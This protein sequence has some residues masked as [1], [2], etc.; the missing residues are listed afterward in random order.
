[1][2]KRDMFINVCI[3]LMGAMLVVVCPIILIWA[4]NTLFGTQT[5]FNANTWCAAL[6]F[7][8]ML[9]GGKGMKTKIDTN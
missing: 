3:L 1:M 2:E 4:I 8:S 5:P 6:V 7:M 9:R